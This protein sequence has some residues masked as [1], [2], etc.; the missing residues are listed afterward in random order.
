MA[1]VFNKQLL[2]PRNWLTWFGLGILWL[3]VQLPYPL[4]HFIGTSAGRLSRRFLKRREHIAR[5]NIE[6]CFPD[7]SPA[8]RETLI[9][10]NFMSLE[11]GGRAM[12]L[13]RPMMATYRP[14]NSPLM[15]WVQTRGRLRSNKAMIDRNNLTGLVHALKS[16]E[17]VWFAPD[18]DYGPK[19]SVFAPFFS[20]PQAAT[21]NGTY[22]LSRLSGAKML[23]ISMVRKLDR[24]GYSLHISE[25][26]NDYP[27]EDKQIAAG[28]INK[29]IERE[30]L[31]AP[32][33]YLWVHRR[34]KTRPLGEPS[35][36]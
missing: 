17:A 30:I 36:Y 2:H 10:Q 14:H 15:E 34:F 13:C 11:L 18:Q 21:T 22:V 19:G 29:V 6:L 20:V 3:I 35:V 28:Y 26:M 23:S 24:Q 27:G 1:C 25:V 8:A 5:R 32:E 31:R 9:D 12:G 4:L 16:G 7:M 33:Q